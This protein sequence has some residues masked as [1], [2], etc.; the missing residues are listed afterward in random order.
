M[1]EKKKKKKK[2]KKRK[3]KQMGFTMSAAAV[4]RCRISPEHIT[5]LRLA[6]TVASGE[7]E[8][9]HPQNLYRGMFPATTIQTVVDGLNKMS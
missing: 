2:K 5:W 6:E 4:L 9:H 8:D 7:S 3:K 1:R